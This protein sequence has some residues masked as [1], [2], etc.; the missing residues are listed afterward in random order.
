MLCELEKANLCDKLRR[1]SMSACKHEL[2]GT[3]LVESMFEQALVH[4]CISAV[5]EE[6]GY[7]RQLSQ[8]YWQPQL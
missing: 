8:W 4:N 1:L 7:R 6:I 3:R 5:R 2:E